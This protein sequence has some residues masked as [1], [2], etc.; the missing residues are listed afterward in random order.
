MLQS[1]HTSNTTVQITDNKQQLPVSNMSEVMQVSHD[2][3]NSLQ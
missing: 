1:S 3:H 2:T